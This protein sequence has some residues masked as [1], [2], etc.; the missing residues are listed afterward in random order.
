MEDFFHAGGVTAVMRDILPL[1]YGD[2]SAV[3]GKALAENVAGAECFRREVI[4]PCPNRYI[5]KAARLSCA[6]ISA[7]DGAVLKQTAASPELLKHRGQAYVFDSYEQMHLRSIATD[8][9]VTSQTVLVMKNAGPKGGPGLSRVGSDSDAA[10]V[11]E[12]RCQGYGADQRCA[13][14]RDKL[15]YGGAAYRSGIGYRWTAQSGAD[16]R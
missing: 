5:R 3:N 13:H 14:E 15:R 10:R 4:L 6:E 12:A 16:G 7:P 9:P 11:V 2:A 8:L 1:L